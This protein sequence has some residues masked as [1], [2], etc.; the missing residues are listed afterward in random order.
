MKKEKDITKK[1]NMINGSLIAFYQTLAAKDPGFDLEKINTHYNALR[2]EV[3]K[4]GHEL[5]AE[6]KIPDKPRS[7]K[8]ILQSISDNARLT[9]ELLD[10]IKRN[11]K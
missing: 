2:A 7:A 3:S 11:L 6:S 5:I 8:K 4:Q 9:P 10:E 1:V